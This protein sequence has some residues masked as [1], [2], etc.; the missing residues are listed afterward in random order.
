MAQESQIYTIVNELAGQVLGE[1]AINVI[2][3]STL[4]SL[5]EQ[6]NKSTAFKNA[7][8]TNLTNLIGLTVISMR[9][10]NPDYVGTVIHAFE[11]GI[12]MRKIYVQMPDAVENNSWNIADPNYTP[13]Y[14]PVYVPDINEDIFANLDTFELPVTIP[15]RLLQGAFRNAEEMALLIAAVFL[16]MDNKIALVLEA[17]VRLVRVSFIARK[18]ISNNPVSSYNLLTNYNKVMQTVGNPTLTSVSCR[19]NKDF[20]R[21]SSTRITLWRKRMSDMTVVFN[22]KGYQRHTP[23]SDSVLIM[24]SEYEADVIAF[25]EADTYHDELV[26]QT[27]YATTN[28]WQGNGEDYDWDKTSSINVQ[29]DENTVV[30]ASGIV[31]MLYDY[32][33]LGVM[34]DDIH[35]V[36]ARNDYD[37]YTTYANKINRGYFN[38]MSENGMVFYISDTDYTAENLISTPTKETVKVVNTNRGR[39]RK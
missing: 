35:M 18:L 20:Q 13:K 6:L 19:V 24:H 28:F 3:T 7:F 8:A 34:M 31:A 26:R 16:A 27:N 14:A 29:L 15:D 21:W 17:L 25:M 39:A 37:E 32:Q 12:Y 9:A 2:D 33:A 38:D 5:G 22:E 30:Q 11:W 23:K 1:I 36:V 4:I 10:Y